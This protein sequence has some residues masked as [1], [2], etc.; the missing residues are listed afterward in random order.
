MSEAEG[1]NVEQD[2]Q[3]PTAG[4]AS[5]SPEMNTLLKNVQEM[6]NEEKWT[7]AAL[8]NYSTSQFKELDTILK[9]AR[10]GRV[11]DELKKTCDDHLVHS[12]TSI[13]ALYLSGMVALSRQHI[14]DSA[15]I[16]LVTIFIDNHKWSIVKYL[17]ER[18]LDYGESK[19]ALHVLYDH[20]KNENDTTEIWSVAKRLVKADYDEADI[21]K[22]LA[23]HYEKLDKKEDKEDA[24]DYYKKAL[25]R[26][27][28]KGLFTNVREIW[29]KLLLLCPED[30]DFYLHVQK[31]IAKNI[32]EDKAVLLL[33]DVYNKYKERDVDT[34]I[35]LLKIILSYDER[36]VHARREIVECYR[37]K[38]A[39]HSQIEEYIRISNLTQNYRNVHEAITDFE[40]HIAFDKGNFVFHRTWGVG[41]IATIQ[42]DDILIDFAKKRGHSM[43]LKMAV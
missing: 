39:A 35:V 40:K 20:L 28:N 30:I 1:V 34:A 27:N 3:K 14:D 43:S 33:K 2:V 22:E 13:I 36:D 15:M 19:F 26:Y 24:I 10:D 32:S 41:R 29:E 7:R 18:M 38:Y 8:S 11:I 4:D 16:N 23:E 9:E 37:K 42:G 31:K 25:H 17:C 21:T 5:V 12:K 6:L